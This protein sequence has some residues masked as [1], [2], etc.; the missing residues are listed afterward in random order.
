VESEGFR[1][2]SIGEAEKPRLDGQHKRVARGE[3]VQKKNWVAKAMYAKQR[4]VHENGTIT[5]EKLQ[6][7]RGKKERVSETN[8]NRHQKD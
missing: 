2:R 8:Y 3:M 7:L 5:I 1:L 6:A 4:D